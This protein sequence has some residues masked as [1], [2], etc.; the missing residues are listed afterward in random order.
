MTVYCEAHTGNMNVMMKMQ[1]QARLVA[2]WGASVLNSR[3]ITYKVSDSDNA[4]AKIQWW[5]YE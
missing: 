5:V 3:D 4:K 2:S 1:D